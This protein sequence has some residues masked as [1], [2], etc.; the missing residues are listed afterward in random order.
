M[1]V[2]TLHKPWDDIHSVFLEH[3]SAGNRR[4]VHFEWE[5]FFFFQ[6]CGLETNSCCCKWPGSNCKVVVLLVARLVVPFLL[7]FLIRLD[8][9]GYLIMR[10]EV[11]DNG[12]E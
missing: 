5:T 8:L 4:Y 11:S 6:C 7:V 2:C 9:V 10:S 12:F 1:Y 3:R